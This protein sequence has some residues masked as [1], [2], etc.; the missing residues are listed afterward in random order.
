MT[1]Q[2]IYGII[3]LKKAKFLIAVS[4]SNYVGRLYMDQ[5]F[6]ARR[7]EIIQI[8]KEIDPSQNSLNADQEN[9]VYIQMLDEMLNRKEHPFYFSQTAN[10]SLSLQKAFHNKDHQ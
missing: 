5:I 9:S 4:E 6:Q 1:F 7:F 8:S 10:I 2:A 3:S